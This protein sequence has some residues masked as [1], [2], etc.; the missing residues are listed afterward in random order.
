MNHH[1]NWYSHQLCHQL[2]QFWV[3]IQLSRQNFKDFGSI[4][5]HVIKASWPFRVG[6]SGTWKARYQVEEENEDD[7]DNDGD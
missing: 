3:W 1:S 4:S 5:R 2:C 7:N 6:N